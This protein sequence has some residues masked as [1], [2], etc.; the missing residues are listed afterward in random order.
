MNCTD[1]Q[2]PVDNLQPI[3]ISLQPIYTIFL[4]FVVELSIVLSKD[5]L[6]AIDGF[7]VFDSFFINICKVSKRKLLILDNKRYFAED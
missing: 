5:I 7:N 1:N 2:L 3:P 4:D 6:W